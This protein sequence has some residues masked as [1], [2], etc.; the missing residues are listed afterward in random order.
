MMDVLTHKWDNR[1]LAAIGGDA[2]ELRKKL[3]G[4]EPVAGGTYLGTVGD[5]WKRRWRFANGAC[6]YDLERSVTQ[7]L[8]D[9]LVSPFTGDNPAT[10]AGLIAT[11]G[12]ALLSLGT[13]T[14]FLLSL[15]RSEEAPKRTITSHLL[16]HPSSLSSGIIML[17]YKNGALARKEVRSNHTDGSWDQFN[18]LL[19]AS[20]AGNN[21]YMGLYFPLKEI[22]PPN[23]QG[24]FFFKFGFSGDVEPVNSVPSSNE[25]RAI[26]ES[27][28]LSIKSRLF[29]I[30]PAGSP[31]LERILVTGGSAFNSDFQQVIFFCDSEA[32][33]IYGRIGHC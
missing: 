16:A 33:V 12:S 15:P 31:E 21:G 7:Y 27:Q 22:I 20:P 5:W 23:V 25:P 32:Q 29:S 28:L 6:Q 14:T 1:L 13:S 17:C 19:K 8:A 10:V 24:N 3:G 26:L 11:P 30:M 18:R 4:L 2:N 9:C